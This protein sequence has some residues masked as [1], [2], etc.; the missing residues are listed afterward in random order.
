[1]DDWIY[2]SNI[3]DDNKIY[4]IKT[5][6]TE[7]QLFLDEAVNDLW[8]DGDWIFYTT[9]VVGDLLRIKADGSHEQFICQSY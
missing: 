4:R 5:N 1:M 9:S 8:T 6:G 3:S 7:R 2:Y